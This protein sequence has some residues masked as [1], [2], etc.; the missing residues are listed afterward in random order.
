MLLSGEAGVG[1]TRL[2]A[3]LA[4]AGHARPARRGRPGPPPP[5]RP[6]GRR[7]ARLPARPS[8]RPRRLRPAARPAGPAAARAGRAG[9]GRGPPDAVRGAAAR[10]RADRRRRAR[11][12]RP[13][14]P[15]VVR[16]G[17]AR[18]AGR[19]GRAARE[20]PL[21]VIAAYRSDGLPRNHGIRRLRN[22]LRRAG[23]LD[24]LVLRPLAPDETARAA[25]AGA[26]RAPGALARP[27][28]PRPHRGHPVL[29][30]GARRGA[31]RQ[32]RPRGGA[33]RA[34]A[35][36]RRR[37]A[38]ARHRARRRPRPRVRALR[39]GPRGGRGRGGRRRAFDLELVASL[40]ERRRARELL[41][42]GLVREEASGRGCFRHAL[43]REALYAD[44]PWMR[45][46]TLHRTLAE[47]LEAGA[48]EPRARAALARRARGRA[49]ARGAAARGG[50]VRG[51]ARVP[52]RGRGRPPGA[53]ALARR[54]RRGPP[55]RRAR[56]LRAL[57]PAL[58][59]AGRGRARVARAVA[60]RAA[61]G[62]AG[63]RR[64]ARARGG[65]R[66]EGRTRGGRRRA[67]PPPTRT[68]RPGG[69][70]RP[71]S[72]AWRSPTS[73]AW[74]PATPTRSSWRGRPARRGRA[75]RLDLQL[76]AIGLEGLATAKHGDYAAG[77]ETVRG[78]LALAL[79]HDL[80]AVAAELY[81]R[82]SV[83]LYDSADY[84]RAEAALDTALELCRTSP[85]PGH[86]GAC[87]TCMAYVLR[88]RGE[89]ARAPR[90]AAS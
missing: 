30:R 40:V 68:P 35:D 80:T 46:R 33:A 11:R 88:E 21:L 60:V 45:R 2:A 61:A 79:E 42:R 13:R 62:A 20:L 50:R 70:P 5:V 90:C 76:R 78:G 58:R 56:A 81:Q 51:R 59:R 14:R 87:V 26:R 44:V 9:R 23:P 15:A 24:E 8:G 19:A 89:W 48:A 6:A 52:R 53:R 25:G 85:D 7:P 16:R 75:G 84:R 54:R 73:G 39:G 12:R 36:R 82:L 55:R 65:A 4:G 31:A 18:G 63:G 43:A 69:P 10:V 32:R 67:R 64:P 83:T 28:D 86:R 57:L 17:D 37:R 72:S 38:A 3:G 22:D 1:K 77:L 34:R 47:A 66:A 49:R 29:R 41:E 27:R 71:P 74:R